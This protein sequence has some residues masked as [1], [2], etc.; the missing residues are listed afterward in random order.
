MSR[1]V[2]T[3]PESALGAPGTFSIGNEVVQGSQA[4]VA[5]T[6]DV[7]AHD[8]EPSS[9]ITACSSN[10]NPNAGLSPDAGSFSEAF[11]EASNSNGATTAPCVEVNGSWYLEISGPD[12]Q[13]RLTHDHANHHHDDHTDHH[14]HDYA[15]IDDGSGDDLDHAGQLTSSA[16]TFP[17]WQTHSGLDRRYADVNLRVGAQKY[18]TSPANGD[19]R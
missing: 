13:F 19:G 7:C 5:I 6:G 1:S 9:T 2:S 4:L 18:P 12:R 17:R 16:P 14:R 11:A 8:E 15:D 3:V 10:T